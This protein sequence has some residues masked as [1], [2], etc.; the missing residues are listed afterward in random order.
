V[1]TPDRPR[2]PVS[3][4]LAQAGFV[5]SA[6]A[7]FAGGWLGMQTSDGRLIVLYAALAVGAAALAAAFS[8]RR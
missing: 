5:A 3:R 6:L 4:W 8:R 1:T 2:S 7:V